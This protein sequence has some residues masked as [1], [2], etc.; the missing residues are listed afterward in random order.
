MTLANFKTI[1]FSKELSENIRQ[2]NIIELTFVG[3]DELISKLDIQS[4]TF[5]TERRDVAHSKFDNSC[6]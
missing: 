3:P 2:S 6:H 1:I 4:D 5:I